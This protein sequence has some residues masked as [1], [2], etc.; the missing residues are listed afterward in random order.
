M[1]S[2]PEM[3]LGKPRVTYTIADLSSLI[4]GLTEEALPGGSAWT[5]FVKEHKGPTFQDEFSPLSSPKRKVRQL[6]IYKGR[7]QKCHS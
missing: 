5:D 4:E 3:P 1:D 7:K 6:V 2:A